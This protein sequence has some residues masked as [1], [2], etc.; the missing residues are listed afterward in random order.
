MQNQVDQLLE[1][2]KAEYL[3][4]MKRGDRDSVLTQV[5]Q[6][7][8]HRFNEGLGYTEGRKY[9]KITKENNGC[10]WGFIVKKDGG[11]FKAGDILKAAGW[12]APATN[13]ARGNIMDA[14]YSVCWTGPHYL[15]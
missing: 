7:M 4:F 6:D 15:G 5:Q 13:A 9:I 3:K 1:V 14:E 10:V 2:I 12:N 8:V 11:K